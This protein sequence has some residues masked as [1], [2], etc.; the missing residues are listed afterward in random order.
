M[1]KFQLTNREFIE[2]VENLDKSIK[3]EIISLKDDNRSLKAGYIWDR[4]TFLLGF[5]AVSL[6]IYFGL[7]H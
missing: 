6:A 4:V 1:N 2:A 7:H 3:S 5:I